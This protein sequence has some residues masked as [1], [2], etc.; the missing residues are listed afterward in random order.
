MQQQRHS[1]NTPAPAQAYALTR[2]GVIVHLLMAAAAL[3]A[4]SLAVSSA[5]Y[6]CVCV[7]FANS[8]ST[9][10]TQSHPKR[11]RKK[12]RNTPFNPG[13]L[14]TA[15]PS[16]EF[17]TVCHL[18]SLDLRRGLE[19]IERKKDMNVSGVGAIFGR[20]DFEVIG[21]VDIDIV[22]ASCV[23]LWRGLRTFLKRLLL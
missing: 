17:G 15:P 23:L 18:G 6:C 1:H 9:T 5:V 10:S 21:V 11:E 3:A 19:E 20:L 12:K 4:A 13:F 7:V 8:K 22:E 16:P 2:T 14:T